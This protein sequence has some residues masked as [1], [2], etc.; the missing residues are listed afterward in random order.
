MSIVGATSLYSHLAAMLFLYMSAFF[1][2]FL[3]V[4]NCVCV[5]V[6]LVKVVKL[7]AVLPA[8]LPAWCVYSLFTTVDY[9][10]RPFYTTS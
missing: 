8:C 9:R 4:C 10:G 3:C 6:P 1:T 7:A 2:C 5:C